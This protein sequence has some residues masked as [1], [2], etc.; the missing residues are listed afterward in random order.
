MDLASARCWPEPYAAVPS[1]ILTAAPD[2]YIRAGWTQVGRSEPTGEN[3][4]PAMDIMHLPL[5]RRSA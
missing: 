4:R 1:V 5:Q 2:I 3:P